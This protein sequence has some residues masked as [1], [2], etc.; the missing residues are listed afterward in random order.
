MTYSFVNFVSHL[1]IDHAVL[2]KRSDGWEPW[3]RRASG[4]FERRYCFSCS[5]VCTRGRG[6]TRETAIL[7]FCLVCF[8]HVGFPRWGAA[9]PGALLPPHPP[10]LPP[11]TWLFGPWLVRTCHFLI[12][13]CSP[14][15]VCTCVCADVLFFLPGRWVR[16]RASGGGGQ[17]CARWTRPSAGQSSTSPAA[18]MP[19]SSCN[20][21]GDNI[22]TWYTSTSYCKS[23][24]FCFSRVP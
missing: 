12:L 14:V 9:V 1:T 19:T 6:K 11:P 18:R 23:R 16:E 17:R 20:S 8:F 24:F 15:R 5:T 3:C 7:F 10:S 13:L 22:Y 4:G 2:L 21:R